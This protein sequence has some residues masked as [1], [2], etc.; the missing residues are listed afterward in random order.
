MTFLKNIVAAF[1]LV[2][3]LVSASLANH[4][5]IDANTATEQQLAQINELSSDQLSFILANRPFETISDLNNELSKTLDSAALELLYA[6]IFVPISLNTAHEADILL[7]PGV[8]ERM[9]NEF[10]EY[11]P[12]VNIEQFR[13]EIGKYVSQEE[14]A[15]YEM[16]IYLA[17]E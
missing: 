3:V 7:I 13:R 11:R 10:D 12:Y 16:Y 17:L 6:H 2:F 15:R 4:H 8:G 5:V 1:I 14:V 9:A